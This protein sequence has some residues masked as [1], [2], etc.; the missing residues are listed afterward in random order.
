VSHTPLASVLTEKF[1]SGK[2]NNRRETERGREGGREGGIG[3]R[4]N[5]CNLHNEEDETQ[6]I[7]KASRDVAEQTIDRV[8]ADDA[9]ID[10]MMIISDDTH[11]S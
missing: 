9:P 11:R 4:G 6:I 1:D 2:R 8:V 3:A 5:S 10:D 7:K